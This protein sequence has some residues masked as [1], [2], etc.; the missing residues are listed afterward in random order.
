MFFLKIKKICL[1]TDNNLMTYLHPFFINHT[2][3]Y[4][5]MLKTMVANDPNIAIQVLHI[6]KYDQR[7]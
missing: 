5:Y 7:V 4:V 1:Y 3:M 6:R 2:Y